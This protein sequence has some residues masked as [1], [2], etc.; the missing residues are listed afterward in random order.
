MNIFE[1][2]IDYIGE[3]SLEQLQQSFDSFWLQAKSIRTQLGKRGYMF[4]NYLEGLFNGINRYAHDSADSGFGQIYYFEHLIKDIE[5]GID[6]SKHPLYV[7]AKT[8]IENYPLDY[9]E[10]Y[11]RVCLYNVGLSMDILRLVS[12]DFI[13]EESQR[14]DTEIDCIRMHQLYQTLC[15]YLGNEQPMERLNFLFKQCFLIAPS[16]LCFVGGFINDLINYLTDRDKETNRQIFQLW[17][18]QLDE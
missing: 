7:Q 11:T 2:E 17:M 13:E 3:V 18:D 5:K 9:Q 15:N 8:F 16:M 1:K 6:H 12:K 10:Q 4:D 14:I